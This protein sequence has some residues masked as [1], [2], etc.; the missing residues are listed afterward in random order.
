V[1]GV[2]TAE[3]DPA[4]TVAGPAAEPVAGPAIE[5]VA[6]PVAGPSIELVAEPVAEPAAEPVEI[7]GSVHSY[8]VSTGVD[9]PG[10]RFVLFT[11]GC[12]LRCLYCANPDTW[13]M[14]D[15]TRMTV[16]EVLDEIGKYRRFIQVSGGG[17]TITG[18]EP[19]LQPRFTGAV[20]RRCRELGLHTALDTSGYLGDRADDALLA[21][22]SLVLLDIKAWDASLYR[23]I[24][25]AD[26][27]P[28][29]RFARRLARLGRPAW[30]RY[31][32]VPGL[33]D[34]LDHVDALA[35]FVAKLPNV[36]HVDVLPYHRLGMF[37]YE[38]LGLRY[39]LEGVR[40]PEPELLAQV[41]ER[42]RAHGVVSR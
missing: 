10:T 41:H 15:G 31:V 19:L 8:D 29:L 25:G 26:L 39:P 2:V 12:P 6:E 14:R 35:A 11:A 18:G 20:L 13:R 42:F 28:T 34:R 30:I 17:V 5:P 4:A 22:I 27:H 36:E 37:K 40:P 24:T 33:T 38:R 3:M 21:D 1:D 7:T 23:R 9:G 16:S 32:L